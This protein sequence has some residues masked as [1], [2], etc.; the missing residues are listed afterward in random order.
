M[1]GKLLIFSAPSGAGKTTIV[2]HLLNQNF[3]LF[4][5]ISACSREK[6]TNEISDVDYHFIGINKFKS[7]VKK[8]AFLEWEEVYHNQFYGTLK[9]EVDAMREQGKHI[10]F[11]VDV[12]GGLNI[13]AHY[14][15]QALAVFVKPPSFEKLK[16]RLVGRSTESEDKIKQRLEKAKK[17]IGVANQFDK[18]LIND[19]L[20]TALIQA[21]EIAR[22]F[23]MNE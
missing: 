16:Q 6:R 18:I 17:E 19:D 13:K 14:K 5:S 20:D 3:G 8:K 9:S 2:Q 1:K 12:I 21:E 11:D 10:I 4:F 23:L 7:L 15:S 22:A